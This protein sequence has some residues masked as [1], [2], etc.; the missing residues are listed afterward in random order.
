MSYNRFST[1]YIK[2]PNASNRI[3][4]ANQS[5]VFIAEGNAYVSGN[6]VVGSLNGSTG[7]FFGATGATGAQGIQGIQGATGARGNTGFIGLTGT[8]YGQGINWNSDTNNWQITGNT[9]IAFG[10]NAG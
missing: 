5:N 1:I 3:T 7:G 4:Q 8:T 9:N 6:L 2:Q 10:N